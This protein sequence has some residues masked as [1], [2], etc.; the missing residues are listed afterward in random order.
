MRRPWN[1][2]SVLS[3]SIQTADLTSYLF[4]AM[5]G[6]FLL[7]F[8]L[9]NTD[10]EL[11]GLKIRWIFYKKWLFFRHRKMDDSWTGINFGP[12]AP[13]I[14]TLS[15]ITPH[16]WHWNLV[17]MISAL[18]KNTLELNLVI[19][20]EVLALKHHFIQNSEKMWLLAH[21]GPYIGNQALVTRVTSRDVTSN[22][23]DILSVTL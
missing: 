7:S 22:G 16:F 8:S 19:V 11:V 3:N 1:D 21:F 17:A 23:C 20:I 10:W 4:C 14:L 5:K 13:S 6:S 18:S 9:R 2:I 15:A 12:L